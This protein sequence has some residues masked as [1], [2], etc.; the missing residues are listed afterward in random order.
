[1][2]N[3][4]KFGNQEVLI[5]GPRP[6]EVPEFLK[7]ELIAENVDIEKYLFTPIISIKDMLYSAYGVKSGMTYVMHILQ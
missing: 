1:M 6:L 7:F 5:Y 4:Y 3:L 2:I